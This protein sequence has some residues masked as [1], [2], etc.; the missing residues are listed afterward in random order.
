MISVLGRGDN[1]TLEKMIFE[2]LKKKRFF[3]FQQNFQF[4]RKF[5]QKELFNAQLM[6]GNVI[7]N[8]HLDQWCPN[9]FFLSPHLPQMVWLSP[10]M[11]DLQCS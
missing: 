4:L 5:N 1:C 7:I 6:N 9:T 10:I 8:F 11:R 3:Y 2:K